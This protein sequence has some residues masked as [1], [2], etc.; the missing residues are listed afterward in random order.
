[1]FPYVP[2][3]VKTADEVENEIAAADKDF[4]QTKSEFEQINDVA[5]EQKDSMK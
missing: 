1:M 2:P 5:T 4:I 3:Q